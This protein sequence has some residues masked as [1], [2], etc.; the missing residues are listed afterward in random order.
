[1]ETF[2][3]SVF[4]ANAGNVKFVQGN[5]SVSAKKGTVRGLH[6]QSPPHAQGKL[7]RCLRGAILDVAVDVRADSNTFGQHITVELTQENTKQLW[8]PA[9]FLHGFVTLEDDSEVAYQ[10][11][12]YYAPEYDGNVLWNDPEI[13]IDWGIDSSAAIVSEKDQNAPRLAEFTT[14]F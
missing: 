2:K 10:C 7:V 8:L 9:G 13:G 14:N 4:E 12:D 11:T 5:Q 3:A 6:Y 1:M